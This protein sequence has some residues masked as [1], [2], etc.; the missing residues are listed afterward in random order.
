MA[1]EMRLKINEVALLLDISTKTIDNWY[2]WKRKNKEHKLAKLLPD[3]HP[4]GNRQTRYWK[5]MD[6]PKLIEFKNTIPHGR[7]GILGDV[8]QKYGKKENKNDK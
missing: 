7:N 5:M 2:M 6:I 1:N 3:F 4:E 8:T